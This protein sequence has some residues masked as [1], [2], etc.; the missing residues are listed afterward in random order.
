MHKKQRK[1]IP[2]INSVDIIIDNRIIYTG[3]TNAPVY[4]EL[5]IEQYQLLQQQTVVTT[6]ASTVL[7]T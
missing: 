5:M 1:N 6:V 7:T 4:M 3:V 2:I